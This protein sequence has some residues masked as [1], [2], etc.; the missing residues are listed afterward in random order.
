MP[1][2][3]FSEDRHLIQWPQTLWHNS[4]RC[5]C[6]G[7]I[8]MGVLLTGDQ[9]PLAALMMPFMTVVFYALLGLPILLLL[10]VLA[11]VIRPVI[12]IQMLY[13]L[14]W[15]G[16]GDPLVFLL[17]KVVPRWVPVERPPFLSLH[18]IIWVLNPK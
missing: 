6:T 7:L 2:F 1:D 10:G 11:K 8:W 9:D 13:A 15:V 4:L 14:F 18:P 16:I 3:N 5:F 17:Q 12:L